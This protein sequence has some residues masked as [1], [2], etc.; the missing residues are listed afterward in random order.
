MA[1]TA[2]R[3]G[4]SKKKP[5][6]QGLFLKSRKF[7]FINRLARSNQLLAG[8]GSNRRYD[9]K[10][11]TR[12]DDGDVNGSVG[13]LDVVVNVT[14]RLAVLRN[15]QHHVALVIRVLRRYE[16]AIQTQH[17]TSGSHFRND[18]F[19]LLLGV[20]GQRGAL[21]ARN[22]RF[23]RFDVR[24][25]RL[26][27]GGVYVNLSQLFQLPVLLFGRMF[28]FLLHAYLLPGAAPG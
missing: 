24:D 8:N 28:L 26:R 15:H 21:V 11:S 6:N 4:N 20:L 25:N 22:G 2:K 18:S 1:P 10:R 3:Y 16:F 27:L 7:S 5:L 17:R 19:L 23:R 14:D 9:R 12:D 13:L